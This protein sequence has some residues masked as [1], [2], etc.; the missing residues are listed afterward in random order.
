MVRE[1]KKMKGRVKEI[2]EKKYGK[3]ERERLGKG[4]IKYEQGR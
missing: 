2:T 3:R 1:R 4:G